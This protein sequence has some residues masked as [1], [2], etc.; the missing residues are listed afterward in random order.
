MR[1]TL[2][3]LLLS[4]LVSFTASAQTSRKV[5][6]QE[7][8]NKMKELK[9]ATLLDVRTQ[10]EYAQG[11]LAQAT[12]MDFYS[13]DFQT[14]VAKLDKSK[15]VFVYCA[16]GGR[17]ASAASMLSSMGFKEIYDLQGGINGWIQAKKPI[18]K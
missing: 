13:S 17:S 11:H 5:T 12:L 16:V 8:E 2:Q 14:R 18:V 7:F 9:S 6:P 4:L 1:Y 3:L 15:P 10:S